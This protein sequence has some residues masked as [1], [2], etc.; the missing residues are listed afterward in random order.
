MSLANDKEVEKWNG[1]KIRAPLKRYGLTGSFPSRRARALRL[2][3]G[4]NCFSGGQLE[5]IILRPDTLPALI[6]LQLASLAAEVVAQSATR[7]LRMGGSARS[8]KLVPSR[9][10]KERTWK[11]YRFL[12]AGGEEMLACG[13]LRWSCKDLLGTVCPRGT[14]GAITCQ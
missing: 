1:G 10:G 12:I 3:S 11:T 7:V 9:E 4:G 13:Q 14:T 5:E 6:V 8:V 2:K